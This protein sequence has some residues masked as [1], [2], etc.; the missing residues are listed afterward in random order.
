M[1]AGLTEQGR[2]QAE[3]LAARLAASSV[4]ALYSS[5]LLRAVETAEI[6]AASLG[7]SAGTGC[8][9]A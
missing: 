1:A 5:D 8:A 6:V 9:L 2:W 7:K 4:D 3:R